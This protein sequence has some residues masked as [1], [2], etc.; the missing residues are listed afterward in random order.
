MHNASA[1]E[2]TFPIFCSHLIMSGQN[3][4]THFV[5]TIYLYW[6]NQCSLAPPW[7]KISGRTIIHIKIN[8]TSEKFK[9][10]VFNASS[11]F[12]C[13]WKFKNLFL[14]CYIFKLKCYST[15]IVCQ[16]N[17]SHRLFII[18]SQTPKSFLSDECNFSAQ[19]E[20]NESKTKQD[21]KK[22]EKGKSKI[23]IRTEIDLSVA[24]VW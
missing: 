11:H 4:S 2:S 19:R 15:S 5:L 8:R 14:N 9:W 16:I 20:N 10:N 1:Y 3:S 24:V 18:F 6:L 22:D 12:L 17:Y 23:E 21:E 13:N 7:P